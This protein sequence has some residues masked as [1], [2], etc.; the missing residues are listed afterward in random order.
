MDLV[1]FNNGKVRLGF[2][3]YT[4]ARV[5]VMKSSLLKKDDYGRILKMGAH[6]IIR[7]LQEGH[8]RQ[9]ME[10]YNVSEEGT[11]TIEI[12]LNANLMRNFNKLYHISDTNMQKCLATYLLRYDL[13]NIKMILRS[14]FTKVSAIEVEPLLYHSITLSPE[15]L[16]NILTKNSPEE[17]IRSLGFLKNKKINYGNLFEIE[18]ALDNYYLHILE[19][20]SNNLTGQGKVVAR[21][22]RQEIEAINLKTIIKFKTSSSAEGTLQRNLENYLVAPSSLVKKII[23][24]S[25]ISEIVKILSKHKYTSLQGE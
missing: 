20:L 3:P 16:K 12:A 8:Y 19:N 23:S 11:K 1:K 7:L 2:S 24:K 13:E 14:K 18:N 17:V 6:E 10:E 4:Y 5:A 22:L 15:L 21:F 25:N 9:E